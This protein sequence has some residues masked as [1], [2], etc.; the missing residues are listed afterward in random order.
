MKV[1]PEGPVPPNAAEV[2]RSSPYHEA[3]LRHTRR[4]RGLEI[5]RGLLS[6]EWRYLG[7]LLAARAHPRVLD[8]ACGEGS[9]SM[10][11]AERGARAVG[12][13]IDRD[14]LGLARARAAQGDLAPRWA[15]AG[16][17]PPEWTCGDAGRLPFPDRCFDV[18]FC[19]SLLEHVP[20]WRPV[21]A[22]IARV[23][24]AGGIAVVY[25]T[26]GHCPIQQEVNHFPFYSWLPAAVKRRVLRWIMEHR[27]DLVNYTDFPAVNWFTFPGMR[28]AFEGVGLAALD[29]VDLSTEGALRGARGAAARLM[30]AFPALKIGYYVGVP[31]MALYGVKREGHVSGPSVA[32]PKGRA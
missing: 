30:R 22:E 5:A 16:A 4:T 31:A 18:V 3:F 14:L 28:R 11:W 15:A 19:N 7:P 17:R 23:L 24:D 13:D 25:T 8:L 21:L 10:A 1:A 12:I 29:R 26:N 2:L 32:P 20:A 6:S 27:R 9:Q